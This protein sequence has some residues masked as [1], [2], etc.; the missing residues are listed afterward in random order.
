MPGEYIQ[1]FWT[2]LLGGSGVVGLLMW[3]IKRGVEARAE[4]KAQEVQKIE[5]SRKN[6]QKLIEHSEAVDKRL[7]EMEEEN[8]LQCYCLLSCLRG[9]AEQGCNGPVHDGIN[10]LEKYLNK[11]A[12]D[13]LGA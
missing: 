6:I 1:I 11:K 3:G 5:V 7:A 4:R 8:T 13:Q 10:R 12:H 2:A 9:L